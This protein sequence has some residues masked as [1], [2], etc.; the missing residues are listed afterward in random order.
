MIFPTVQ[1]EHHRLLD[2]S[3]FVSLSTRDR[4]IFGLAVV[5]GPAF[6][7]IERVR[8]TGPPA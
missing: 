5:F 7:L 8:L 3:F 6:G 2:R 1:L 4:Q